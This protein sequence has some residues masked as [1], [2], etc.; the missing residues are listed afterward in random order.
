MIKVG[1]IGCGKIADQHV[2]QIKKI[3]HANLVAVCDNEPL[4]AEQL[5]ERFT[6]EKWYTSPQQMLEE[7]NLD[8]V[9]ITTPPQSHFELGKLCL[10]SGVNVYMEKPFT[11]NTSEAQELI[12]TAKQAGLKITA[13]HNAQFTPVMIRM[14]NL[15]SQGYLGGKPVHM[16]S[17][18][19]YDFRD[20]V[21]AKALLGDRNHWVRKLPGSLL[22]NIIS[23][24]ISKIAEVLSGDNPTVIAHCCTS[25][26]LKN[27]GEE[28]IV[29]E[30]RVIICDENNTTA[31]FTF[32]SQIGSA[33]REFRLYGP[34]NSLIVDE[35]NQTLILVKDNEYKSYLKYFIPP[36][37]YA[38]QYFRNFGKNFKG[39]L[40]RE[41]H[42]PNDSG[43]K[44]LI[45][46]FY[47]SITK[48]GP[49]PISYREILLTTKIMDA[50]FADMAKQVEP[51]L[52]K[53]IMSK[54]QYHKR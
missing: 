12:E 33:P 30:V 38:K 20:P 34:R 3:S 17:H 41:F 4:M 36:I 13:G 28:N 15:V 1:I 47:H 48:N 21:F 44:T 26:L 25:S 16:E 11:L 49:L 14:R 24:G 46:T 18:Y 37:Q 54:V 52:R 50:I 45:E 29:D 51:C 39:F 53:A 9:H 22:H 31:Y 5:A 10:E 23:H 7:N 40:N 32:S 43:L 27:I 2:V 8:V 42:M 19:C 6:I 35:N